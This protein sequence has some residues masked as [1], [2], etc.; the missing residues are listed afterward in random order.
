MDDFDTLAARFARLQ[1]AARNHPNPGRADRD[2]RLAAL[3]RLLRDN[4]G[5]LAEAVS[6]DFGHRSPSETRLLELFPS[7]EAISHARRHLRCWMR[8]Q[9]R[10]VALW[11]QPGRAE[12]RYQPLGAVGII[13]PWNYPLYLAV[14]P[15]VAALAAGNRALIKMSEFT[16]ATARLF[17]ELIAQYFA[18]DEVSVVEG[19]ASVAQAFSQLPFDH[20]LFTGSTPVGRHVMRAA[21]ENLTPVTLELGGKSPAIIGPQVLSAGGFDK[22]VE[23]IIIGKCLNAGQTCIAPD[24]VLLPAGQEQAFVEVARRV[25]AACYP[26]IGN[27][28]DYTHVVNERHYARLCGYIDDAKAQGAEVLE[29]APGVAP[30]A[31]AH[32]LPPLVLLK[33]KDGMRVMQEEIFGPLLPIVSYDNL[34]QAIAF[35]NARPRP[36]ALYYFDNDRSRIQRVLNET[37]AGGVTINDTLMHIAQDDLPFGGVGPS[38]MGCYHGFEGFETFSAKKAVFHQSRLSGIGLFKP[39]YG[40]RFERLISL[41][42]R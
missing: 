1:C 25:V 26:A 37:V 17:A 11:F 42:L 22:A 40:A 16:P 38:G 39:P 31:A 36:L 8:P 15:L 28:P 30:D 23:R 27:T 4:A 34:D 2:R 5:P 12:V 13:V 35:V 32:R 7:Y 19:D 6:R 9:R 33:V 41:L 21:A 18:A 29:L 3:D 24:Y 10:R 14:G 20:L